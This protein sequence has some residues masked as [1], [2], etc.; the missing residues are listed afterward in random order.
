MGFGSKLCYSG[1][2]LLRRVV[3]PS[4]VVPLSPHI[5]QR[6]FF[7]SGVFFCF[8]KAL[9]L[10]QLVMDKLPLGFEIGRGQQ[11]ELAAHKLAEP[12]LHIGQQ[13]IG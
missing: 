7:V 8:K 10:Q 5:F 2:E 12:S 6:R 13:Q 1:G 11:P 4:S 3:S 9:A